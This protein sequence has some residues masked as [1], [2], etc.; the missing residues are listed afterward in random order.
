[1]SRGPDPAIHGFSPL[2]AQKTVDGRVSR[3]Q[4]GPAM[5]EW[6]RFRT[7]AT[8]ST[9]QLWRLAGALLVGAAV[10]ASAAADE[11]PRTVTDAF[12]RAV[13]IPTKPARI[14]SIFAS[15]TEMLV[16]LGVRDRIVGIE[17]YTRHPPGI[18]QLPK[19]GGRLGFSVEAVARLEPDLVV[20]TPA[21]H[22]AAT[23]IKPMATIGVPV[24]VVMHRD[25]VQVFANIAL[26]GRATGE[27]TAAA[28]LIA[29]LQGRLAAVAARLAGRAPRRVYLEI[30]A[31][32]RG[33]FMT[34]RPGTYTA[35]ALR[36]AG[37]DNVFAGAPG[38]QVSGE[39]VL[40]ADPD[41]ILLAT[42][43]TTPAEIAA[44]VGWQRLTAVRAGA[45]LPVPRPLLLIPGP[46]IVDGV[47]TLARLLHPD[48]FPES[49]TP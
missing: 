19:V 6:K 40:H 26:L 35:D 14:V 4:R 12:G 21:R 25:I 3:F 27:E 45:V 48:A 18:E 5:T 44:R 33:A 9:G 47:E 20:V 2:P 28:A 1:M 39:A 24:V 29:R 13:T 23:L 22:A 34:V 43:R 17:D 38:P 49:R 46:R 31:A 37:G 8:T 10:A 15:N 36:L 7:L 30:D 11:F 32:A 41:V 42:R 16:A